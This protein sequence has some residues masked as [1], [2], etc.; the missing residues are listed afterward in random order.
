M[1]ATIST[2]LL[3]RLKRFGQQHVLTDWEEL[4]D[5]EKQR[6]LDQLNGLDL[7]LLAKLYADRERI[8]QLPELSQIAPVP[9]VALESIPRS[10]RLLGEACLRQGLVAVLLVAGG[11]GSRL[12]F[13]QPKGMFPIGPVSN[14][15]LFQIHAEKVLAIQRRYGP[16]I[17]FLLLT[18]TATHEDTEAFFADHGY[19]GLPADQVHFFRQG[20]LPAL[21]LEQGRLLLDRPGRL[22][23]SPNGHGGALPA[24]AESGLLDYLDQRGIK[25]VFYFQ[26]DN[27]LVKIADPDFLG[28]HLGAQAEVS[29]KI[30]RKD[31]ASDR[32]GNLVL[33]DGRCMMIE[34]SDLPIELA[35]QR[36][37]SGLLRIW[38]GSPA[39]HWFSL[40]FLKRMTASSCPL[41]YHVAR[42][43]VPCW[44]RQRGRIEPGRENA[45]K[46]E[47]FIFDLLPQAKRWTVVET[48]REEE[49]VPLKNASGPD[50]PAVVRQAISRLA[51]EWL[52][53]AGVFV[54][55]DL[56]G[57]LDFPLEI[58]PLFALDADELRSKIASDLKITGPLYLH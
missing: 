7:P 10:R 25:Q 15:S 27:P 17:P 43:K 12:G 5:L 31:S 40:D 26:V 57:D 48:R 49:F 24:L 45:L 23:S 35:Q 21:D 1:T 53:E 19:F 13:E 28:H 29:S 47:M 22:F 44:D 6:L 36:D 58:S 2:E 41:P 56:Q 54:P 52:Q 55:R 51:A 38:A 33:V 18:S 8:F 9:V 30:V 42:K 39:I 3:N 32:L 20:S 11:Q 14:K 46:F 37:S 16:T 50:S 34:Y 4:T